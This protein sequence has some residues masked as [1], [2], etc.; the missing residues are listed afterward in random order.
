MSL[1]RLLFA[2]AT[3]TLLSTSA[4]AETP[5]EAAT[6]MP[7]PADTGMGMGGH[8]MMRGMFTPEERM[9]LFADRA[10]TAA[11][12]S[13]DQRKADRQAFRDKIMAM[14]DADKAKFKADLDT[15][16]NALSADQKAAITAKFQ[17]FMAAR[18]AG[19]GGAGQ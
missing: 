14:S 13:E 17:A 15:R 10:K 4:F 6:H 19:G 9:M 8:G 7:P 3:V 1:S 5:A 2:A 11:G 12:M 16:W 18:Q